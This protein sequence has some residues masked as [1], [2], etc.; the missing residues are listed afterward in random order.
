MQLITGATGLVGSHVLMFLLQKGEQ[1]MALYNNRLP[2]QTE[3]WLK[4]KGVQWVEEQLIWKRSDEFWNAEYQED[5]QVIYHCAA[6]V[7]YHQKDHVRMMEVN[8]HQTEQWVNWALD[9][10]VA[11]CHVS[12]I[13]AL[14]KANESGFIDEQ[15]FWQPSKDHTE[16]SR[17]KFLS[18][19]EV[20][21]GVE[22]GLK[23][24]IVNPGII[25]G[26]GDIHQSSGQLF[27][28]VA[29]GY[30]Y[31]PKGG[32]GWIGVEDVA[33]I[34]IELV[35]QKCWGERFIL[36]AENRTM[37][38]AFGQMAQAIK[39]PIPQR[40]LPNYLLR[41]IYWKDSLQEF[42]SGKKAQ[43]TEETIRNT[44]QVKQFSNEK[45]KSTLRYQFD[46]VED[47]IQH[48]ARNLFPQLPL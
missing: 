42:F 45:V 22:E 28:T 14:G 41:L 7:S 20:W 46:S 27:G 32:T 5:F 30:N 19:M 3:K 29:R 24:V 40:P 38:W 39:L 11:F 13:A 18:E 17:T 9:H 12:S 25:I 16:Y 21:R 47:V 48:T 43:V 26:D 31:F 4:S 35:H 33:K 37:Q 10:Q 44:A 15:C 36:V 34:M 23:A 6:I 1:V 8:V 2:E